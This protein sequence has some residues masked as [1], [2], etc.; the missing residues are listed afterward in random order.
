M[1]S[2]YSTPPT[3]ADLADHLAVAAS[4]NTLPAGWAQ[5]ILVSRGIDPSGKNAKSAS[6]ANAAMSRMQARIDQ[7][8]AAVAKFT[9]ANPG[10]PAPVKPTPTAT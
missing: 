4:H 2:R 3:E 1:S 7:L 8:E 10:V 9:T 6:A 5:K